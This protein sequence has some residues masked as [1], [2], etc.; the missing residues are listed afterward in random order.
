MTTTITIVQINI[1]R[2][3]VGM[4]PPTVENVD[5]YVY[6]SG[7][8]NLW[9][10]NV[11]NIPI[12]TTLTVIQANLDASAA[13][14]L[15]A[16]SGDMPVATGDLAIQMQWTAAHLVWHRT[17]IAA[18]FTLERAFLGGATLDLATY[19]ST[20]QAALTVIA[21]LPTPFQNQFAN[22]RTARSTTAAPI[23]GAISG[24]TL[25]SC[26]LFHDLLRAWLN[27]R[28]C[29]AMI[30]RDQTWWLTNGG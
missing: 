10:W 21:V 20:L 18:K 14:L 4:P 6:D 15:T 5:I 9:Q 23:T 28:C 12:G 19:R 2:P 13:A 25:A 22:E 8:T 3:P 7:S 29:E 17:F 26:Q 1:P 16:C 27:D 30:A 11:P 24:F